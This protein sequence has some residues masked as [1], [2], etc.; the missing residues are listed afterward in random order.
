MFQTTHCITHPPGKLAFFQSKILTGLSG[1]PKH[2]SPS[3]HNEITLYSK[4]NLTNGGIAFYNK[5]CNG[6]NLFNRHESESE[7]QAKVKIKVSPT[8]QCKHRR[9]V[10]VEFYSLLTLAP[11]AVGV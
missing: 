4:T 2:R 7:T 10:Q 11:D 8:G 3:Y 5:A 1:D 6:N 9:G